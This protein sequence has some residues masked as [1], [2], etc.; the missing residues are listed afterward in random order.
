MHCIDAC[1]NVKE[2]RT[3]RELIVSCRCES[4]FR[5]DAEFPCPGEDLTRDKEGHDALFEFL[6]GDSPRHEI[7]IVA[8]V[9]MSVQIGIIL[10]E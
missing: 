7:V 3:L 1:L 9:A 4:G 2:I 5:F 10:I 8:P 6:K